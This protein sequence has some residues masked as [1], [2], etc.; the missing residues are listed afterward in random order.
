MPFTLRSMTWD[1]VPQLDQLQQRYTA[2]YPP[3]KPNPSPMYASPY[4]ADGKNVLCAF[5]EH[6]CLVAFAPY[7]PQNDIA[8]VEVEALPELEYKA[9]VKDALWAWLLQRGREDGMKKLCFQYFPNEV[10]AVEFAKIK[11]A[12]CSW[13]I[14]GMTR[15]LSQPIPHVDPPEGFTVRRWR[16]ESEAEQQQYL[17]ARNAAFPEAPTSIEEWK[18]FA[19]APLW[20]Q[21]VNMA[22]FCGEEQDASMLDASMLDAGMLASSVLVF[23]EPGSETGSTEYVFTRPDFRGRGLARCLL[24]ESLRYL[25]GQ[26]LKTAVLEVKAEN[27]AALGVYLGIGYEVASESGVYEVN[28]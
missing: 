1:D 16:M 22:A 27:R 13:N 5:D 3:R 10:E 14:Y 17:D 4:F 7:F 21:G 9:E 25:K 2:L 20:E 24:A 26:G 12:V 8:W 11:G 6:G 23:F 15:D 18:F 28:L 19:G